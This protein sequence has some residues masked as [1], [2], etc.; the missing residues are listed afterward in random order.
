MDILRML[1]E[2]RAEQQQIDEAILILERLALG[3]RGKRRGRPPKWMSAVKVEIATSDHSRGPLSMSADARQRIAEPVAQRPSSFLIMGKLRTFV[4]WYSLVI[5]SR[6][7]G[8]V[9]MNAHS[10]AVPERHN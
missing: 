4:K 10:S 5:A 7:S 6:G 9:A 1:S 8:A 2:L 3:V